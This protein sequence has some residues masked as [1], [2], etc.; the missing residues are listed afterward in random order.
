[1]R[2]PDAAQLAARLEARLSSPQGGLRSQPLFPSQAKDLRAV[3]L[4]QG[5]PSRYVE[6]GPNPDN[7]NS[8]AIYMAQVRD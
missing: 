6:V 7:D 5:P 1:M 3:R 8:A 2:R 4:P